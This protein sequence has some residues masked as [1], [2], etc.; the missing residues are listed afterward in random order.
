MGIRMGI[1][2]GPAHAATLGVRIGLRAGLRAG[3][4]A[5][6][7]L[8]ACE[9]KQNLTIPAL[10]NGPSKWPCKMRRT[11]RLKQHRTREC[12]HRCVRRKLKLQ[13]ETEAEMKTATKRNGS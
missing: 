11:G 7:W 6:S 4:T 3:P 12:G 5:S 8:G 9:K 10:Q 2:A 1:R 13:T